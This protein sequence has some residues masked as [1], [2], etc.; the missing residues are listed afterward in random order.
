M[1]EPRNITRSHYNATSK[2]ATRQLSL[3]IKTNSPWTIAKIKTTKIKVSNEQRSNN[4]AD[5]NQNF[6]SKKEHER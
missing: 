4:N 5:Q 3:K 6:Q 2:Q 1:H